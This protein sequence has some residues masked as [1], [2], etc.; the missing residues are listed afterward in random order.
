MPERFSFGL[1]G[2]PLGHSISPV[3]HRAALDAAELQGE[4]QLFEAPPLPEG[5]KVLAKLFEELR[6][7]QLHGLNVTIPHKQNIFPYLDDITPAAQQI[8]AVNVVFCQDGR[9]MG[10]NTDAAGFLA[11]LERFLEAQHR[12]S[13][14]ALVLGAGGSA[15]AVVYALATAGWGVTVAARRVEQARALAEQ[16]GPGHIQSIQLNPAELLSTGE[17]NLLVNTTPLGMHPH[18]SASPW[19]DNISLPGGAVVYDLVYN[20]PQ[21]HLMQAAETAGLPACNGLGMLVEQAALS[22]ERWTGHSADREAMHQAARRAL[23]VKGES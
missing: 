17:V 3:L 16:I 23:Q 6:T 8:G 5:E 12:Q 13:G 22:F 21:T 1:I 7:R 14:S 20:P 2:Y 19:P 11:D 10:D 15:R 4:Y 9:L 18:A